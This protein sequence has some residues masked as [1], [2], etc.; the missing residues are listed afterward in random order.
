MGW[1]EREEIQRYQKQGFTPPTESFTAP[2]RDAGII[3]SAGSVSGEDGL[4]GTTGSSES[5][6]STPG[7]GGGPVDPP[8]GMLSGDS[9]QPSPSHVF[10]SSSNFSSV[11]NVDVDV[12]PL[13]PVRVWPP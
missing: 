1:S 5:E 3:G 6:G 2:P 10:P 8:G 4:Q 12:D 9:G 7:D 13:V 11:S